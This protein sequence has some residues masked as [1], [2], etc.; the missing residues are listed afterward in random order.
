MLT[1]LQSVFS[2][3]CPALYPQAYIEYTLNTREKGG[4]IFN[5]ICHINTVN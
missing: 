1:I 3:R 5:V 4:N 2:R